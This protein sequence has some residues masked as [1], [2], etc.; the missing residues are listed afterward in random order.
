M[1]W[2]IDLIDNVIGLADMT[3]SVDLDHQSGA[4]DRRPLAA[5]SLSIRGWIS[6]GQTQGQCQ[7]GK[8]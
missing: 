1:N 8:R 7:L 3:L 5:S 4:K 2:R 6:P